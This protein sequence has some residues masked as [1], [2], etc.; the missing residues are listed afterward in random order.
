MYVVLTQIPKGISKLSVIDIA[1]YIYEH[2]TAL[3]LNLQGI[4]IADRKS[5]FL[6]HSWFV[7]EIHFLSMIASLSW[8]VVQEEIPAVNFVHKYEN[9]FAFKYVTSKFP[10][11][12]HLTSIPN[13][14]QSFMA[15]LDSIATKCNYAGYMDKFVT[16]PP[17]GLLPLPGKSTFADKGCDVWNMIFN[18]AL[19][20]NPAFN[21]YRIF[22]TFPILWDV[23]GFPY[24][25]FN[26]FMQDLSADHLETR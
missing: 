5:V 19:I 20:V 14:S 1:N 18:A 23:L 10:Y 13:A 11:L 6:F 24:V 9:V 17:A 3:D 22:D 12:T 4:W 2:P 25:V 15:Q 16:Y 7:T 8:T 21:I 26:A